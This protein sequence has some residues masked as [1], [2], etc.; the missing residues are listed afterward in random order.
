MHGEQIPTIGD[1]QIQIHDQLRVAATE[2][3]II[4]WRQLDDWI[5]ERLTYL[6]AR[7]LQQTASSLPLF[8]LVEGLDDE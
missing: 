4:G 5:A 8:Y 7:Y 6:R 3:E 2:A 1:L